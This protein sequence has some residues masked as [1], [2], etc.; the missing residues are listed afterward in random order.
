[1]KVNG[2]HSRDL[3]LISV[4]EMPVFPADIW[5]LYNSLLHTSYLL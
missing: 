1:M 2:I 5:R 4:G 3:I